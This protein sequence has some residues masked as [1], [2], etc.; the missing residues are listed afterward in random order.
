MREQA[1]RHAVGQF[2]QI[3]QITGEKETP[4]I[5]WLMKTGVGSPVPLCQR[6]GECW[7]NHREH[8]MTARQEVATNSQIRLPTV[9]GGE[10][11][12]EF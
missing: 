12:H 6:P 10:D 11:S 7:Q 2:F 1:Q 9:R 8:Q 3:S 4:A 5:L